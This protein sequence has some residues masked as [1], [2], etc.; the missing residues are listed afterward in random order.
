VLLQVVPEVDWRGTEPRVEVRRPTGSDALTATVGNRAEVQTVAL[1]CGSLACA[2]ALRNASTGAAHGNA[3][4][5]LALD[6]RRTLALPWGASPRQ[7]EVALAAL[8]SV[9]N[10]D[11]TRS[12]SE[13]SEAYHFGYS[14]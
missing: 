5:Q 11:V 8:R 6:S 9:G 2:A 12:G 1:R 14:T 7:V 4:W 10:V 13:A 3:T